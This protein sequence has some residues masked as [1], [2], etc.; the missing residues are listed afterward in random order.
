LA[1]L[2]TTSAVCPDEASV[3]KAL[4]LSFVFQSS[5]LI[6]YLK[7]LRHYYNVVPTLQSA[8]QDSAQVFLSAEYCL[9]MFLKAF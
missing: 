7:D 4:P 1:R 5:D 6:S 9:A 3:V 2:P 8:I